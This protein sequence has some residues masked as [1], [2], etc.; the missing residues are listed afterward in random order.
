MITSPRHYSTPI[1]QRTKFTCPPQFLTTLPDTTTLYRRRRAQ[2]TV[3]V[4]G[5]PPPTV[6]W[7]LNNVLLRDN[8]RIHVTS[9]HD[10]RHKLVIDDICDTD[11]GLYTVF[12]FNAIDETITDTYVSVEDGPPI[13]STLFTSID[14]EVD[15]KL[16]LVVCVKDYGDDYNVKWFRNKLPISKYVDGI[17]MTKKR[18]LCSLKINSVRMNDGGL[19]RCVVTS[20]K[21]TSVR[22]NVSITGECF[23]E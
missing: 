23:S 18:H 3:K 12:A 17:A 8:E 19:Y 11:A 16:C 9:S 13:V 7:M 6:K 15:D 1:K 2:L 21:E 5:T 10:G 22:F 20:G 4:A 14:L